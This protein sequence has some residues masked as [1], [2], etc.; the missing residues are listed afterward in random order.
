MF[1]NKGKGILLVRK[2]RHDHILVVVFVGQDTHDA[3]DIVKKEEM[4]K[5]RLSTEILGLGHV[6]THVG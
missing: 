1:G 5:K 4:D 6:H 2:A 3:V